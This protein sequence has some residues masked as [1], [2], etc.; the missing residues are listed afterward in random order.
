M[1]TIELNGKK[2]VLESEANKSIEDLKDKSGVEYNGFKIVSKEVL[3]DES[4]V[5]GV[6]TAIVGNEYHSVRLSTEFLE[7]IIKALK[8][9]SMNKNG[10][11]A[12]DIVWTKDMPCVIGRLGEKN[13]VSGFILAPRIPND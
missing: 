13:M 2:Y 8:A 12:I 9:I 10:L 7:K 4:N 1:E 5:L 11:D 6:G 3:L